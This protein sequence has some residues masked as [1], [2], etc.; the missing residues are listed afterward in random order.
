MI[1]DASNL[2]LGRIATKAAKSAL[3]GEEIYIVN[4]ENAVVTGSKE[5][6]VSEY[7]RK[8]DMG[9]FKGPIF[10]RSP[11]KFVKRAIRG[12][13]PRKKDKGMNAFRRIKCYMGVPDEFKKKKNGDYKRG[14][15]I[16]NF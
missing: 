4:C 13:L 11:E 16:K 3:M 10:F 5:F 1:I 6:I 14:K 12:M 15:H 2:V 7:I 8:R 9:T